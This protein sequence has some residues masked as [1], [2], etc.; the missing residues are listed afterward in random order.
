MRPQ[1]LLHSPPVCS[2]HGSM[3][4]ERTVEKATHALLT[5]VRSPSLMAV[6]P[7]LSC[8]STQARAP[9][10]SS[11]D[12]S[13]S[14][15]PSSYVES[16]SSIYVTFK[17]LQLVSALR[18]KVTRKQRARQASSKKPTSGK[19]T[20]DD[21][22]QGFDKYAAAEIDK[23]LGRKTRHP[24]WKKSGTTAHSTGSCPPVAI[25]E[26]QAVRGTD[27]YVSYATFCCTATDYIHRRLLQRLDHSVRYSQRS[28]TSTAKSNRLFLQR[29]DTLTLHRLNVK[30][31]CEL[32]DAAKGI[33]KRLEE[34]R[35][36]PL[37][38]H[39]DDLVI[40][41]LDDTQAA[42]LVHLLLRLQGQLIRLLVSQLVHLVQ[43]HVND[44][45]RD[46]SKHSEDWFFEFPDARHP[47]TTTFP[48]TIKASLV[49]LWGVCWM[50][51]ARAGAPAIFDKDGNLLNER[52]E[53]E[54]PA[55]AVYAYLYQTQPVQQ[56]QESM[57]ATGEYI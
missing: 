14:P 50:F 28:I 30:E 37:R 20:S 18:K 44:C 47:Q 16:S 45:Q 6:R 22:C 12:S 13:P 38:G 10:S 15:L 1:Q 24:V 21:F 51:E 2:A 36:T 34:R 46:Q 8:A 27:E 11:R 40:H 42:N 48:W 41:T 31:L 53:I 54:A 39:S 32:L 26:R 19:I 55:Q 23:Y 49:V 7:S 57:Q 5:V 17:V 9:A 33:L 4:Q 35:H 56:Q 3:T 52:G 43:Q 25:Q 29:Q